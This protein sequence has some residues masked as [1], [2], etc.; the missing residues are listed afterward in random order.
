YTLIKDCLLSFLEALPSS[1]HKARFIMEKD[2]IHNVK[3]KPQLR[4]FF[5]MLTLFLEEALTYKTGGS[6]YLNAYATILKELGDKLPGLEANLLEVMS[7]RSEIEININ[8]G[9]LL[10]HLVNVL[11]KE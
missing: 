11:C 5:D 9:L 10:T 6:I 3:G 4:R 7:M 8:A 1:R 2:V